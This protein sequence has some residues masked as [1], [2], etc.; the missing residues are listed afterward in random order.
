MVPSPLPF[1][2]TAAF[3]FETDDFDGRLVA[4]GATLVNGSLPAEL[5]PLGAIRRVELNVVDSAIGAKMIDEDSGVGEG[6]DGVLEVAG[7]LLDTFG[8]AVVCVLGIVDV[9][10]L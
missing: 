9:E 8:P 4:D 10:S 1:W 5:E 3:E 6:V 7:L 2:H